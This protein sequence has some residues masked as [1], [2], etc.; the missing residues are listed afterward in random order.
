LIAYQQ[1]GQIYLQDRAFTP[2][3]KVLDQAAAIRNADASFLIDLAEL[4]LAYSRA[5]A[6]NSS[7]SRALEMLNRAARQNPGNPL[8]MQR[9]AEGFEQLGDSDRAIEFTLKL[10]ERFPALPNWREKLI[11]LYLGKEDTI[12]A[13]EL[14]QQMIREAPTDPRPYF[15][16]GKIAMQ[17]KKPE[18]AIEHFEK[19]LLLKP[20]FEP[21]YYE[22]AIAQ[23]T[24]NRSRNAL[25]TLEKARERYSK[26]FA[27]EFYTAMAYGQLKE[28]SNAIKHFTTAEVIA[29]ATATN[30]LTPNFYFQVGSA[31]ERNGRYEEAARYFRKALELQPNFSEA[32][33][34]LGYMWAERGENLDEAKELIEKAVELEPKN[35]AFLDSLGWVFFKMNKPKEA[36]PWLLKAA[37]LL[38]QPDPTIYDHLGDV[39]AALNQK[40][41]AREAWHKALSIEPNDIKEQVRKKLDA[42]PASG[43]DNR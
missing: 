10:K 40:A 30:R 2:G 41:K 27:V 25:V 20:D 21:A 4:Y 9:L 31:H 38:E 17:T 14:L 12:K 16:L 22:L 7:R 8:L 33:N 37:E 5:G 28:F 29:S 11:D 1:L 15:S 18:Q 42:G 39:Y 43:S 35:A 3:L 34:Y 36:L 23:M 6:T 24:A 26:S 32:L 19:V 13:S